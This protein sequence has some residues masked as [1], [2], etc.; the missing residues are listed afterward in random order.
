MLFAC[1]Y[2][3]I[4]PLKSCFFAPFPPTVC[5]CSCSCSCWKT[6]QAIESVEMQRRGG[7]TSVFRSEEVADTAASTWPLWLL[8]IDGPSSEAFDMQRCT[9]SQGVLIVSCPPRWVTWPLCMLPLLNG[10]ITLNKQ[11]KTSEDKFIFP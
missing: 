10:L 4:I 5:S 8:T 2:R 11:L 1:S 3:L 6:V 7:F 9:V